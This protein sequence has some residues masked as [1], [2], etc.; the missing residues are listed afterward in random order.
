MTSADI[1]IIPE[2]EEKLDLLKTR[3]NFQ[4][5]KKDIT[6]L[7][8]GSDILFRGIKTSSGLQTASLKSLPGVNTWVVEEAEELQDEKIFDK[9]DASIRKKGS[10]NLI[11]L[12]LN[13]TTRLH[14]IWKRWLQDSH[15][16]EMVDGC[17]VSI[18]THPDVCHIHMTYLDN[19]DNLSESFLQMIAD[20][21]VKDKHRYATE[22]IGGWKIDLDGTLYKRSDVKRFRMKDLKLFDTTDAKNPVKLYEAALGYADVA[23]EG[24]DAFALPI[25]HAFPGRVFITDI[26][27]TKENAD[28]SIPATVAKFKKND[29][30]YLRVESNNQGTMVIRTLRDH[31][32]PEKILPVFSKA[33]KHTRIILA[34]EFIK[35][36]FY[37]LEE[38]EIPPGSDYA[39]FMQQM[40]DYKKKK[41]E[42]KDED[43]APDAISGLANFV[44]AYLRHLFLPIKDLDKE[45]TKK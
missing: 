18:S 12:V 34:Y 37:F 42:T 19:L 11:I 39:L 29:L 5:N 24:T 27:F 28:Y 30:D 21:K 13:P 35:H 23:D 1:S 17:P 22:I 4:V 36:Y 45:P 7:R 10:R 9:I 40:F 31:L 14:W 33:A 15:R 43:D 41:G 6:N 44:Q 25:G 8:S 38:D 26:L 20:M 2:F 16:I 3:G 32:P